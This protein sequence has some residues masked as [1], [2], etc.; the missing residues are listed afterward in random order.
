MGYLRT[1]L[2]ENGQA[3]IAPKRDPEI[4]RLEGEMIALKA[5]VS[6][7]ERLVTR[8]VTDYASR[9][10][11]THLVPMTAAERQRRSRAKKKAAG[12]QT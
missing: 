4:V 6:A 8:L 1:K 10:V 7:L 2:D 3:F 11:V 5:S 12:E 9:E